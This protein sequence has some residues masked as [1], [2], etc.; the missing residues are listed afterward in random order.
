[1]PKLLDQVR[2]AMRVR[3]TAFAPRKRT[4]DGL[5]GSS[6]FKAR[7]IRWRWANGEREAGEILDAPGRRA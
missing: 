6:S 4:S 2:E 7:G 5:G 1:M 3:H